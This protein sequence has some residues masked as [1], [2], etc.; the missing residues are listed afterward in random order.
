[1]LFEK[2][3]CENAAIDHVLSSFHWS[4]VFVAKGAILYFESALQRNRWFVEDIESKDI[5]Y[6]A[7]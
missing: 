4:A 6:I 1:M 2:P 3:R 5:E 7:D